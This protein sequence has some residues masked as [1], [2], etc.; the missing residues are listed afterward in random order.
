MVLDPGVSFDTYIPYPNDNKLNEDI[1]QNS[2]VVTKNDYDFSKFDPVM[3]EFI[4]KQ[5]FFNPSTAVSGKYVSGDVGGP[6]RP[7]N[8]VN[9]AYN[10]IPVEYGKTYIVSR[11]DYSWFEF[12]SN[13]IGL[14][15]NG[16]QTPRTDFK[17]TPSARNVKYVAFSWTPSVKHIS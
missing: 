5:N 11:S 1:L 8:N 4:V 3:D 16:D 10:V 7:G 9:Y 14:K 6:L 2:A 13:M 12:D 15:R 17:Y